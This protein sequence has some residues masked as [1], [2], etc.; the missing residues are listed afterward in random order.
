MRRIRVS[1]TR[2]FTLVEMLIALL[3][4]IILLTLGAPE[5][6]KMILRSKLE[7]I[8]REASF[9][10]QRARIEAIKTGSAGCVQLISS[11]AQLFAYV[12]LAEVDAS[13]N[14]TDVPFDFQP[15][16]SLAAEIQDRAIAQFPLPIGINLGAPGSE[17][18]VRGFTTI[19][20]DPDPV[21]CFQSDGSVVNTGAYRL[22][23]SRGNYL[24]IAVEPAATGKI[25]VR[26]WDC[27]TSEWRDRHE[28][29]IWYY[30]AGQGC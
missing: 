30:N 1:Q 15:N 7:S 19:A 21:V 28:N 26:K 17:V 13:G 23:D 10:F 12:D 14:R 22:A 25:T 16:T 11:E 9:L 18:T 8:S 5:L 3:I 27:A 24:E 4:A 6:R 29:W 20:S 2:G